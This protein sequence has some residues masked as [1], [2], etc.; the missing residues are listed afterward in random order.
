[1][2]KQYLNKYNTNKLFKMEV[3][4]SW[5]S[6]YRQLRDVGSGSRVPEI[7]HIKIIQNEAGNT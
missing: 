2:P 7:I 6:H 1:L 3:G 4:V 5:S